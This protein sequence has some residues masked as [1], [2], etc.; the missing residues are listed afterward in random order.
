[1]NLLEYLNQNYLMLVPA[2]WVLGFALKQTPA[3]P[4]WM[5]IWVLLFV[6]ITV[7]SLTF[8]FSYEGLI[9][10]ITAAGVAVLGHQMVKQALLGSGSRKK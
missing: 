10:G 4:N 2:L 7:G 8:G 6:S 1:M 9:N 3:I 5:I